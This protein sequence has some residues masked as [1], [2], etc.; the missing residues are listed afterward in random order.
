MN[1]TSVMEN[2]ENNAYTVTNVT[3]ATTLTATFAINTYTITVTQGDNGTVAPST[4]TVSY[5]GS[6]VFVITPQVGYHISSLVVDGSAVPIASTYTFSNIQDDHS[7]TASFTTNTITATVTN[8]CETYPVEI[9]GN[10]TTEQFSNM[11]ITP[12]QDTKITTVDFTL[13]GPNGTEG[14]CNLTLPKTRHTLW[15]KPSCLHRRH[16]G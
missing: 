14:F 2:V 12:Y 16:S 6:Q 10:V 13:T 11:T 7:I 8:T 9:G 4:S 1:G 15:N 5:G 3:G